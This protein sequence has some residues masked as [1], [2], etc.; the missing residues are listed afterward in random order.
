VSGGKGPAINN[1]R[2][3]R[4][5][6]V[7][8]ATENGTFGVNQSSGNPGAIANNS[9]WLPTT[10]AGTP[11]VADRYSFALN[12]ANGVVLTAGQTLTVRIHP[13]VGSSSGGRYVLLRNVTLKSQQTLLAARNA[14]QTNLAVYPN[15]TQSQL[16]VPHTAAS[17]DARVTVFS[18]TGSKVAAFAAQAGS[19]ATALD[20]SALPKGLYLVE[21][22]DGAQRSSARIVKE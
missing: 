17:R 1:S 3:V 22:A 14:V 10:S 8:D 15:P 16:T 9:A 18:T 21:Y 7:L 12:G 11:T 4:P 6:G 20:L 2:N 13:A 5:G 19:T